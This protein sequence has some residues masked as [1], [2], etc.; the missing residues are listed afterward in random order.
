MDVSE[1]LGCQLTA[2]YDTFKAKTIK[3]EVVNLPAD[4]L[5]YLGEYI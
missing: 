2:W 1:V 4:F 5:Q 3:S